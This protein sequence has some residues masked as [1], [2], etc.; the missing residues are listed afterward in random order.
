[1]HGVSVALSLPLEQTVELAGGGADDLRARLSGGF[2]II[3]RLR[4]LL[5]GI[6]ARAGAARPN[7]VTA[8][9]FPSMFSVKPV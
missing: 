8:V 4:V 5:A 6:S 2:Y 7:N 3:R 9:R 1:M